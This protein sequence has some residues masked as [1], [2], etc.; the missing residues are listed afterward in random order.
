MGTARA[1]P[2]APAAANR[3]THCRSWRSRNRRAPRCLCPSERAPYAKKSATHRPQAIPR[4]LPRYQAAHRF[5]FAGDPHWVEP[6]IRHS[7]SDR[8]HLRP[9]SLAGAPY[10]SAIA[11]NPPADPPRS[12]SAASYSSPAPCLES[13]PASPARLDSVA[14]PLPAPDSKSRRSR[15]PTYHHETAA[16]R[17]P[18]RT[19]PRQTKTDPFVHPILRRA[20]APA[21]YMQMF[22][23]HFPAWSNFRRRSRSQSAIPKNLQAR[24]L[25]PSAS[26]IQSPAPSHRRAL[27]QTDSPV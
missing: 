14:Q 4:R 8:I 24:R 16:H 20:P 17:S 5:D 25:L 22:L 7:L 23:S 13:L 3:R 12:D 21:T 1:E 10:P 18:F 15:P 19:T 9:P 2:K 11:A 6:V 26:P 27:S